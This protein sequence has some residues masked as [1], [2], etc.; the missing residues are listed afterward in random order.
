MR[1]RLPFPTC[2]RV[3]DS[4]DALALWR[5]AFSLSREPLRRDNYKPRGGSR[6]SKRLLQPYGAETRTRQP[7]NGG[8]S[9]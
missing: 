7:P 3:F 6:V 9:D 4:V 8:M 1:R 5:A 2:L